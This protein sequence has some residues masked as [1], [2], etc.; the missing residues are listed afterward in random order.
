M[1]CAGKNYIGRI[2]ETMGLPVLDV[3]TQGHRVIEAER[4]T[5]IARF[6]PAILDA[7]GKI[8]RKLLG[9]R[10]F[11]SPQDLADL[12]GII[13]PAVNR[14]T[15]AWID[16]QTAGHCVI[17]AALLHRSAALPCLDCVILV[18]A[19]WWLRLLRAKKRD[20]L[21]WGTLINR[22][23]S[24]APFAAQYTRLKTDTY[25]MYNIGCIPLGS[26]FQRRNLERRLRGIILSLSDGTA[27]VSIPGW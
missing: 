16:A 14:M 9:K 18:K 26:R 6:G 3:D 4:E 22:F 21:P 24:Q 19:P 8:D 25:C 5:L 20:R 11:G 10:V 13:H 15:A 23:K 1:Y 27:P 7:G 12:E 17:N 2:L